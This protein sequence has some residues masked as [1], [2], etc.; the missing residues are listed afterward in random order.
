[1]L[2]GRQ[3]QS[4]SALVFPGSDGGRQTKDCCTRLPWTLWELCLSPRGPLPGIRP[5][6]GNVYTDPTL[7]D[8]AGALEA[9]PQ[10][11]MANLQTSDGARE[12]GTA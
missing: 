10:L 4:N 9:L 2:S 6:G 12:T 11:R 8:V 1:M 3:G 7:L 5:S